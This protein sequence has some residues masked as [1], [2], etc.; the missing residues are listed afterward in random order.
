MIEGR[1]WRCY[2]QY[3]CLHGKCARPGASG[4]MGKEQ[5][6]I[7]A[8]RNGDFTLVE[9]LL[10][11][12]TKKVGPIASLRRGPGPNVTDS[13]GYSA[14]HHA[15]LNG[16]KDVVTLLLQNDA[17]TN[18][19]DNRGSSPLHLAAW[20]GNEEIVELL[21]SHGPS[22][23][24]VNM[25]MN[26]LP[27]L[28]YRGP[29]LVG[30]ILPM[31]R[32]LP[33]P[34]RRAWGGGPGI[35]P[36][37]SPFDFQNKDS[38]TALHCASQYGHTGVVSLLLEYSGDPRIMNSRAETPL[39]LAARYGRTSTVRVLLRTHPELI[40]PY[41]APSTAD[42]CFFTHTPLHA[43][44]RNGHKEVVGLLLRAGMDVNA[45]TP[46]GSALHEATLCGK[47]E[48]FKALIKAGVDLDIK[49]SQKRTVL[50]ILDELRTSVTKEMANIVKRHLAA[51]DG[52]STGSESGGVHS[53]RYSPFEGVIGSES[54]QAWK[55][56]QDALSE[57]IRARREKMEEKCPS[58]SLDSSYQDSED[59]S[60][61]SSSRPG[62]SPSP[63]RSPKRPHRDL[64]SLSLDERATSNLMNLA[65]RSQSC[66]PRPKSGFYT[67]QSSQKPQPP[68]KPPRRT[69]GPSSP[70]LLGGASKAKDNH[71]S[72][73]DDTLLSKEGK[74]SAAKLRRSVAG[75]YENVL[76]DTGE[77]EDDE[78]L[79]TVRSRN[80][81]A[82]T[83]GHGKREGGGRD[84]G[85]RPRAR[86]REN[87]MGT[88]ETPPSPSKYKQPPTPEH[89][90]PSARQAETSIHSR[91]RPIGQCT[92]VCFVLQ[93][94]CP[95]FFLSPLTVQELKRQSR[96]IETETEDE[97]LF[98]VPTK[99]DANSGGVNGGVSSGGG[100]SVS[101]KSVSTVD[102]VQE[103]PRPSHAL[104]AGLLKGSVKPPVPK[105]K[106]KVLVAMEG[107]KRM[108]IKMKTKEGEADEEEGGK[109][110]PPR[111]HQQRQ[112]PSPGSFDEQEEWAKITEIMASLCGD[113]PVLPA[114][115]VEKEVLLFNHVGGGGRDVG[116]GGGEEV[117]ALG[118]WLASL[119]LPRDLLPR[120]LADGF[121]DI[122]FLGEG[123]LEDRDLVEM[124]VE[125]E[126]VRQKILDS[127]PSLPTLL[128]IPGETW[129]RDCGTLDGWLRHIRL[130]R[131][132]EVF[133]K[134]RYVD[135]ERV[136]RIW[137]VELTT[138]LEILSPGHRKRILVSLAPYND[139]RPKH[140]N[141]NGHV[142][143]GVSEDF[144]ADLAVRL[145][146]LNS[147]IMELGKLGGEGRARAPP[148]PP[149]TAPPPTGEEGELKIRDPSELVMGMPSALV[150][151]WR[152][153]PDNL[154]SGTCDYLAQYLGST[155][156]K[157]LQ[158]TESSRQS[159]QKLKKSTRDIVKM[160]NI[161]LAISYTGVKF[162][163]AHTK[164]MVCEHDIRNIHCACQD[165]D[166]LRHFA[167]ITR[168]E[169]SEHHYC[170]DQA[171]E[172]IL[173]LGEA[174]EVAYQLALRDLKDPR[175]K[176]KG[177]HLP[178]HTRS[179]SA[180]H[181][182]V[183]STN[184]NH[185]HNNNHSHN[186]NR[187][188]SDLPSQT[189]SGR[190]RSL[191]RKKGEPH[192]RL[193][194]GRSHPPIRPVR[195]VPGG[196][197]A[198]SGRVPARGQRSFRVQADE[199]IPV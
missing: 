181:L 127:I 38:E 71:T 37:S 170:H 12:R 35:Q 99:A 190:A 195:G 68:M 131:Y 3:V 128:P 98:L 163:D 4:G 107:K 92:F 41:H 96:D 175:D 100:G 66:I 109:K 186:H 149:P 87:L 155:L 114:F 141:S 73:R 174:F 94:P 122:H 108:G 40:R 49:D 147:G 90:P 157:D 84:G 2:R 115:R 45:V 76:D 63:S 70:Y 154:I 179:R 14:L 19:T 197:Q 46:G 9:K 165:A 146:R 161:I 42:N 143:N 64:L 61:A 178:Q 139:S 193:S 18:L 150:T 26:I 188:H 5:E 55:I 62:T 39:D 80:A 126:G 59:G 142:N 32:A 182:A 56:F 30:V 78:D 13:S 199:C 110:L 184:Q 112:S 105:N 164:D 173:T 97:F 22:I 77:S 101:D 91:I 152:H 36:F 129:S 95:F 52:E 28:G 6:L 67:L 132:L 48:V 44:A 158:G 89:P 168:D 31:D 151:R 54:Q 79:V 51:V 162:I 27:F 72:F 189:T 137:E 88:P 47:V 180:N 34:G 17:S 65:S 93:R 140:H 159:I 15:A 81:E 196:F 16:H 24:D 20:T 104:F 171:T 53:S 156:V 82:A 25:T 33:S 113:H 102:C 138:V 198:G 111:G 144:E 43:A 119:D 8:A 130:P 160:P 69:P 75:S 191:E 167:Y 185:N 169:P 85:K 187:S 124:G 11:L 166:D 10:S 50:D 183:L 86:R 148:P 176:G 103:L 60:D 116:G 23:P 74:M 133:R 135:M 117:A 83:T 120:F 172:I 58:K 136:R 123:V 145:Q 121:D 106:P 57:K 134:N 1:N 153:S 29:A 118:R 7:D 21:L 192:S 177:G 125:D 194:P